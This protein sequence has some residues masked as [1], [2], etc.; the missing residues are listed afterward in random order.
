M[1]DGRE[2]VK[3]VISDVMIHDMVPGHGSM[4]DGVIADGRVSECR[5]NSFRPPPASTHWP[6]LPLVTRLFLSLQLMAVTHCQ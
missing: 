4:G 1:H 6:G 3:W 2:D 5:S